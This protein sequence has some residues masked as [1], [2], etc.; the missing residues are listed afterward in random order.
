MLATNTTLCVPPAIARLERYKGCA[1]TWP[2]VSVSYTHLKGRVGRAVRSGRVIGDRR[3]R[4]RR[5]LEALRRRGS[6]VAGIPCL[7][8]LQYDSA[9]TGEGHDAAADHRWAGLNANGDW[10]TTAQAGSRRHGKGRAPVGT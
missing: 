2:S 4:R 9:R 6:A 5:Y 10:I 8:S 3:Q 1:K 7:C